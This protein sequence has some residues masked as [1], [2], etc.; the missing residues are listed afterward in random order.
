MSTYR[1]YIP[2]TA[3]QRFRL[4]ELV[5]A[6]AK[7]MPTA[8][9]EEIEVLLGRLLSDGQHLRARVVKLDRKLD[10]LR[11]AGEPPAPEEPPIPCVRVVA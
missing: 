11:V 4:G 10:Q 1:P 9:G 2:L 6:A 8:E 5:R 7:R 3:E